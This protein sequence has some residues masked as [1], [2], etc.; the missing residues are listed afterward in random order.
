M[1]KRLTFLCCV[2]TTMATNC[3]DNYDRLPQS[4][5]IDPDS[6]IQQDRSVSAYL[7]SEFKQWFQNLGNSPVYNQVSKDAVKISPDAPLWPTQLSIPTNE[8]WIVVNASNE[9]ISFGGG[10]LNGALH[11]YIKKQ[12]GH[13]KWEGLR[14]PPDP[15]AMW[16][17]APP[18]T[19]LTA[20]QK[21]SVGGY[22]ISDVGALHH[23]GGAVIV[24]PSSKEER[25][26]ML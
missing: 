1:M 17:S 25:F 7:S 4:S 19:P 2:L 15:P 8:M 5:R 20:G 13:S 22:A 3:G 6:S 16:T 18:D 24:N 14:L 26:T 10:G 11:G 12:F 23:N 21:V 9:A